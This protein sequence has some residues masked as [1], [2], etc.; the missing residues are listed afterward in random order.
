M[1]LNYVDYL[2]SL[3]DSIS[4]SFGNTGELLEAYK[5]TALLLFNYAVMILVGLFVCLAVCKLISVATFYAIK[6]G[7]KFD[8]VYSDDDEIANG[9]KERAIKVLIVTESIILLSYWF[10]RPTQLFLF[11]N[12]SIIATQF[13]SMLIVLFTGAYALYAIYINWYILAEADV[14][15]ASIKPLSDSV[16]EPT[17]SVLTRY[18]LFA[19]AAYHFSIYLGDRITTEV[20]DWALEENVSREEFE[21]RLMDKLIS[22]GKVWKSNDIDAYITRGRHKTLRK[23]CS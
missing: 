15:K 1:I 11:P 3:R 12:M 6:L 21:K 13:N 16:Y 20:V 14:V 7:M 9:F 4:V 8:G 10:L 17:D 23:L 18:T 5:L 22:N 2:N 19:N